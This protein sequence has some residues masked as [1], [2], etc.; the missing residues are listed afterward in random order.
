MH[1]NIQITLNETRR[2]ELESF[3][4]EYAREAAAAKRQQ[5]TGNA[6]TPAR[7]GLLVR[8]FA[9]LFGTVGRTM[10]RAR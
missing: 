4:R 5:H 1:G 8:G 3:A 6:A 7:R 9:A 2:R 10:A